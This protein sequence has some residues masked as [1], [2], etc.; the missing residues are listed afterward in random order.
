MDCL[1]SSLSAADQQEAFKVLSGVY[2][3]SI[4][5]GNA[6]GVVAN[7]KDGIEN[8][9]PLPPDQQDLRQQFPIPPKPLGS[10]DS[11]HHPF[12]KKVK[13]NP[14]KPYRPKNEIDPDRPYLRHPKYLEYR[15]RPRQDIGRDGKP[16][17]PD[18]IEAAFQN[19]KSSR[20]NSREN[21]FV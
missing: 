17:W 12:D 14:L 5:S 4:S 7:S 10:N 15:S 3:L 20:T 2:P 9:Y 11:F 13:R 8:Q 18:K 6:Q 21:M 16:I 19:G 1:H